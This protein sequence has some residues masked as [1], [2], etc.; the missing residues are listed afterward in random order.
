MQQG[1]ETCRTHGQCTS[2]VCWQLA[3]AFLHASI[4]MRK[5]ALYMV[6][7]DSLLKQ[8]PASWKIFL[9][10]LSTFDVGPLLIRVHAADILGSYSAC[11]QSVADTLPDQS[12]A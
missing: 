10:L 2:G 12:F 6:P 11:C 3:D 4:S 1:L 9:G 5:R 7:D 8:A